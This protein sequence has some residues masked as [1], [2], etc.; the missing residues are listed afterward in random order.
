MS[1]QSKWE[2][3]SALSGL[4]FAVLLLIRTLVTPKPPLA[5]GPEAV[6]AFFSKEQ[7]LWLLTVFI[8]GF[9]V[10][11]GTWFYGGLRAYLERAGESR[12]ATIMFGSWVMVGSLALL[13][14]GM[15]AV[16]A[17]APVGFAMTGLLLILASVLLSMVWVAAF[18]ATAALMIA[19]A[20]SRCFPSWFVALSGIFTVVLLGGVATLLSANGYFSPLGD[21]KNVVLYA[22]IVWAALGSI[23]LFMQLGAQ[24]D[25]TSERVA[26]D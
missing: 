11:A 21:F 19:A 4:L 22:Y 7:G 14:H 18:G 12:L 24:D 9:V 25:A 2:R 23:L 26:E 16:P 1:S 5:D 17:I 13:R 20:R 3:L 10:L 6:A 15:L 8:T